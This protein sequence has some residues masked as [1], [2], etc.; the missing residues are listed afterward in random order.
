MKVSRTFLVVVAV[1][2]AVLFILYS[3]GAFVLSDGW[4]RIDSSPHRDLLYKFGLYIIPAVAAISVVHIF[5]TIVDGKS[6]VRSLMFALFFGLLGPL[7][8]HILI[9]TSG[10]GVAVMAYMGIGICYVA[11]F[12]TGFTASCAVLSI[13]KHIRSRTPKEKDDNI[14]Q[15]NKNIV[16]GN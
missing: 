5:A 16:E 11:F 4:Q 12:I 2:A 6:F 7:T 15:H 3:L 9:L 14:I 8:L 10:D 13:M 1:H